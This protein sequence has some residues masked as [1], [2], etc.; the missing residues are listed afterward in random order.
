MLLHQSPGTDLEVVS[1]LENLF[2]TGD[3]LQ[4][5]QP[6]YIGLGLDSNCSISL[7]LIGTE[8]KVELLFN[9]EQEQAFIPEVFSFKV[10]PTIYTFIL[11]SRLH[12]P[13]ISNLPNHAL[14]TL[15]LH[16][17]YVGSVLSFVGFPING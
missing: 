16:D 8:L 7:V 11:A 1:L 5:F 12:F 10:D 15:V 14:F 13:L 9:I 6:L 17:D 3:F 4:P 2:K